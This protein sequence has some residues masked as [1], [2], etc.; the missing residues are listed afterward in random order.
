VSHEHADEIMIVGMLVR[1]VNIDRN[2][3]LV[4]IDKTF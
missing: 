3:G 2:R 1:I 4:Y